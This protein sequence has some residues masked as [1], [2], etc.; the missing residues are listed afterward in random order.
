MWQCT[1]DIF[2]KREQHANQ[3]L[4]VL[5][6]PVAAQVTSSAGRKGSISVATRPGSQP[7][8]KSL[9]TGEPVRSD[10]AVMDMPFF[11]AHWWK[12]LIW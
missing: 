2:S 3:F 8:R 9:R 6:V 12:L 4:S 7:G 11:H 5:L 10:L 1:V